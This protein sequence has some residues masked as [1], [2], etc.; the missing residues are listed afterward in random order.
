MIPPRLRLVDGNFELLTAAVAGGGALE[1]LLGVSVADDWAG[2][3]EA[4]PVL[5]ASYAKDPNGQPWGSLFFVEP[6]ARTLVGFGGFKGPPSSDGVVEIGYAIAPAFRGQGLATDAVAQMVQRAFDDASVRAVDAHTLGHANPSTRVLEKSGFLKIGKIND[7]D[8]GVVWHWRRERPVSA[9]PEAVGSAVDE[10]HVLGGGHVN[11]VTRVGDTVRRTA[12]PWTPTIHRLLAHARDKGLSWVPEPRGFDAMGREMLSFI[13][14]DVPHE[15]PAWVWSESVLCDVGRALRQWHDATVDFDIRGAIWNLAPP[16]PKEVVCHNDFAPY[17]C[18]FQDGR[19]AGAIDFDFCAPGPRI[20]DL[21]YTAYRFVPLMPDA[22][23]DRDARPSETS[24]F[25]RAVMAARLNTFLKAYAAADDVE[26]LETTRVL[27]ATA[28]RLEAI[29][30]WTEAHVRVNGV[31]AL[32]RHPAMY[33]AHARWL[34][35]WRDVD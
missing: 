27:T 25:P 32:E 8:E 15:M 19:F 17:N 11:R 16:E 9:D 12:G 30:T 7:P 18:V 1:A 23:A 4:L 3:P 5:R 10:E 29:A 13:P 28:D 33:R 31:R 24:P 14:G 22:S 26:P 35:R 21:A 2:F 34:R 6:H 20:W